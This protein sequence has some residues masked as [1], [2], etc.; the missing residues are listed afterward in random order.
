MKK[1]AFLLLLTPLA[2]LARPATPAAPGLPAPLAGSAWASVLPCYAGP[3]GYLNGQPMTATNQVISSSNYFYFVANSTIVNVNVQVIS[4]NCDVRL[5][6]G[7]DEAMDVW[8]IDFDTTT[9]EDEYPAPATATL[10]VTDAYGNVAQYTI[11]FPRT[12]WY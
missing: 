7:F 2:S 12:A 6:T 11:D 9:V 8:R 3:A 10:Q 4:S 1:L 5:T